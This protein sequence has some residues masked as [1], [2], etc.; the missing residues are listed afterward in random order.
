[1]SPL[2][3][4]ATAL[5]TMCLFFIGIAVFRTR[6]FLEARKKQVLIVWD[7]LKVVR[8]VFIEN[9][10]STFF[11]EGQLLIIHKNFEYVLEKK[12]IIELWWVNKKIGL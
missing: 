12:D 4:Q 2:T 11:V 5:D 8:V 7:R 10:K 6:G 3:K 1:M 9:K